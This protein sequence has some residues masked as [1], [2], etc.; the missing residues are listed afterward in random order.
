VV[1]RHG[2]AVEVDHVAQAVADDAAMRD[3]FFAIPNPL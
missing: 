2:N 1:G 3:E